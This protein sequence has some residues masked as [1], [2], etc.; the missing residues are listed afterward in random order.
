MSDVKNEVS[1][2]MKEVRRKGF[3]SSMQI[4]DE[5]FHKLGFLPDKITPEYVQANFNQILHKVWVETLIVLENYEEDFYPRNVIEALLDLKSVLVDKSS[6]ISSSEGFT[7]AVVFLFQGLYPYLRQVF[8]SIGQG[9]MARG[10]K[11]FELQFGKV[12]DL[13]KIPYQKIN[14]KTRVD[15]IFLLLPR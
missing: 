2:L 15:F 14:R 8:R 6:K 11:D 7:K 13:M 4:V 5:T 12:L 3:P 9:R 10:G 1:K